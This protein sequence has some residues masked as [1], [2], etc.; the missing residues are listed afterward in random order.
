MALTSELKPHDRE[1][2]LVVGN[3]MVSHRFCERLLE[4]DHTRRYRV[5]VVGEETRPAYDR[6]HLTSYFEL[7]EAKALELASAEWYAERG[8]ELR[9]GERVTVLDVNLR[10]AQLSRS[11][12]LRF[13]RAVLATGSSAFVPPVRGTELA[14]VF[15]YR[16]LDDLDAIR[17]AA[18]TARRATVLG[19]GLL[20][21]EAAKALLDLGIP[22]HVVEAAPRLMPR[23]LDDAGAK[24]LRARI[25]A[26]GVTV[27]VSRA[28]RA[29]RGS[30]RVEALEF[31]DGSELAT[32]LLV[33]SAGIR[34]RD[35]LAREAGLSVGPRGG[36]HVG[37]DLATSAPHV[38]AIGECALHRGMVYGLV[39]PGYSMAEVLARRLTGDLSARFEGADLSTRLK[40]LGVDVASFGDPFSDETTG[41]SIEYRNLA[42]GV[43]QKLALNAGGDRLLGGV[44]VGDVR[45]FGRLVGLSKSGAV[46][47]TPPESLLWEGNVAPASG[48]HEDSLP[49][50]TCNDVSCGAVRAAVRG[51]A[52]AVA[53]VKRCTRA[54][55]GC[56]GCLPL[57]GEI[58]A[59]E[60]AALGRAARPRLCEHFAYT[61]QELFDLVRVRQLRSF[62]EVIALH[63]T[64]HGCEICKPTLASILASTANA[65]I[66]E[67]ETLQDTNDRFLANI[68]RRGL[69]S[70]VPRIPGGEITPQRLQT[71]GRIAEKYDLY[72][73]ITGGQRIDLFGA[74]L[75][76]LPAIWGE[77]IA[78]GFESGHAYG[79]AVRTVK[80]CV[81]S[82][83][84]RY[85]VQ[86]SVG[87]AIRVENRYKGIR[88]PHK[89]K[90]AVSG[91]IRE[92][93]EAQSKDFGLIATDKGWN[94]YVC[95][96]GG[97]HP[98]H[99]D[100]LATD[101]DD[102]RALR[103]IDRFLMFYIRTADRLTRTSKW[104][105]SLEGGISYLRAVVVEDSLGIAAELEQ[106]MQ[107]LVEGYRCEWK[108]ALEDPKKRAR[109]HEHVGAPPERVPLIEERGQRRPLDWQ[110][111][112]AERERRHL[113]LVHTRWVPL[114]RAAEFPQDGGLTVKYG[115]ASIAIFNF[116]SRGEWFATQ[117]RCP[118]KGDA[119]LGRGII[120]DAAGTPK[121][122]CPL[123][124]RAFALTSGECL[125]EDA[126]PIHV[127]PVKVE[128]GLVFLELPP[129]AEVESAL[130]AACGGDCS[131]RTA[132]AAE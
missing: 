34:P 125:T 110:P 46:L 56:G 106:D 25:E 78:A 49:V 64:G 3:G 69:Y 124:K 115:R 13:H 84:C 11:G 45:P 15:V 10:S 26:L 39:A 132:A 58:I 48:A 81:G 62:N 101:L 42:A 99:A 131:D 19:G 43:Y 96:N 38:S 28:L 5:V 37:D 70:V 30:D 86:D 41:K 59:R 75:D 55:T 33:I 97:S 60:L 4:L 90:S 29:I 93:A 113:P 61:R 67:H 63:G 66:L 51:G 35:E 127:F 130:E 53:D 98:R 18:R 57:V 128:D 102:E 121:V 12:N 117:A 2:L 17:A 104:L 65:P 94:L 80:S 32:D 83:W 72:T 52:G 68:Q 114:A 118:H 123:H 16:T 111:T 89:L 108:D 9:L 107:R 91:C 76:D 85:G 120:G 100:L 24:L 27:D 1:T 79:K 22:A 95:G 126:A 103:L 7:G 112:S 8:I 50:C 23:Q 77:L 47:P 105:D 92:C 54:G 71:L 14:N 20:G 122:A 109:F 74:R 119:V 73:K 44:L 40:L 88:A 21:L 129:V 116:T 82:T 36:I 31:A 87:F 6:V